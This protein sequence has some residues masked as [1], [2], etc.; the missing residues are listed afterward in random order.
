M[1]SVLGEKNT[2]K[3]NFPLSATQT[4][5][6]KGVFPSKMI[7]ST[8]QIK[9]NFVK[10]ENRAQGN[11]HANVGRVEGMTCMP[12][13]QSGRGVNELLSA[14]VLFRITRDERDY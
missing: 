3:T 4:I 5:V 10:Y 14:S 13:S 1:S 7:R 2:W 6:V 11:D 9:T 8:Q 12:P